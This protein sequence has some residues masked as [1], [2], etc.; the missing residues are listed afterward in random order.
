[1]RKK[2]RW[3]A[4]W[5]HCSEIWIAKSKMRC[6]NKCSDDILKNAFLCSWLLAL[7]FGYTLR[8]SGCVHIYSPI[9]QLSSLQNRTNKW[10]L[11][12]LWTTYRLPSI[13]NPS[14]LLQFCSSGV[15]AIRHFLTIRSSIQW[16]EAWERGWASHP[17]HQML[18][19][20]HF[21]HD[22]EFLIGP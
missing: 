5:E 1:M 18:K 20:L 9:M 4:L 12:L 10:R 11:L 15:L 7:V 13:Q 22:H 2:K 6:K 3:S 17:K 19:S 21:D 14:N 16:L 8:R